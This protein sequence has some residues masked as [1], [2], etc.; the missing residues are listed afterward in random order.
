MKRAAIFSKCN[1]F[2][3]ALSRIWD[4]SKPLVMCIG[5]NP[6]TANADSDDPTIKSLI[7]ILQGLGFGGLQML[8]L[9]ALISP[10]PNALRMCPD[11][12]K[13]NDR[14]IQNISSEFEVI[15]FCWGNFKQAEYRAKKFKQMFPSAMCFGK[16]SRGTPKHPLYLKSNSTLI[17]FTK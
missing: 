10:D 11:P 6:S 8:N 13:D 12:V 9:F 4:D 2:R 14:Y 7:R 5:L 3:Y 1:N 16:N 15:V 17:P